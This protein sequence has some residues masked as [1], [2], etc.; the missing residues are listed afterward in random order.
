VPL[1]APRRDDAE[2][3]VALIA[4]RDTADFGR[5]DF[6]LEDLADEWGISEFDLARDAVVAETADGAIAGYAVVRRPGTF[7]AVDPARE[8]QGVGAELLEW[9]E[10]RQRELGWKQHNTVIAAGNARAEA[11]LADRGYRHIRSNWRMTLTLERPPVVPVVEGV[12]FRDIDVGAD[13]QTLYELDRAAFASVA[14][15]GPESLAAFT[16]EHLRAHDL[17][18]SLTRV[19]ERDS[20]IVGFALTRRWA[21]ESAADVSILAV[22]PAEQGRGLGRALL[23]GVFA[24][25][26][27][28]GLAEAQLS[29]A[30]DNPK[31]LRLYEG[32]GMRPRF[33]VDTYERPAG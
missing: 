30:A 25:A 6:T 9:C 22:A 20:E 24:R 2:A 16:E 1:R 29:V 32:V 3:V 4:A 23:S 19:A 13:G 15:T 12:S 14:G 10:A 8:G 31:A 27:A 21:E 5:P 17:D 7:G 11:L 18:V 28:A 33:Q 26:H